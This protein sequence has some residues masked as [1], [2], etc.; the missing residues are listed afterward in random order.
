MKKRDVINISLLFIFVLYLVFYKVILINKFLRYEYIFTSLFLIIIS[1][2][3]YLLLG[4]RKSKSNNKRKS[5]YFF[6]LYELA[7]YFVLFYGSG[8]LLGYQN[9][10]YSL[11]IHKIIANSLSPVLI[12][13]SGEILRNIIIQANKDKKIV[14]GIIT[15]L[16]MMLELF[17]TLGYYDTT[18]IS[19]IFKLVASGIIP[20]LAKHSLLSYLTYHSGLKN[21]L[22]YR[23]SLTIYVY[24]VPIVPDLGEY[25]TCLI[26]IVFP[27]VVYFTV[28]NIVTRHDYVKA[29]IDMRR[30]K[31]SDVVFVAVFIGLVSLVGG[32]FN[33]KMISIASDSMN[34]YIYRGDAVIIKQSKPS[35]TYKVDDVIVFDC[36]GRNTVHRITQIEEING[37][38]FYHTKGD[39]NNAEDNMLVPLNNVYGKVIYKIPYIGYPSVYIEELRSGV[40]E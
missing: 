30:F 8:L 29:N 39:N 27:V 25:L 33:H 11:K 13:I 40:Y 12:I 36:N 34:P 28:F 19:G 21:S 14:I 10:I 31:I 3:S 38:I 15:V 32:V 17:S 2:I 6:L 4:Y 23:L 24:F 5:I 37:E 9:N 20:L 16:I 26:D 35:T 22:I 18:E 1:F 7:I